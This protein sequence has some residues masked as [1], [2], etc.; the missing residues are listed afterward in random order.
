MNPTAPILRKRKISAKVLCVSSTFCL[1][2]VVLFTAIPLRAGDW[3][4]W[5][6]PTRTG[7]PTSDAPTLNSLPTELKPLW[8]ISIG[9]GFSSP[10][11]AKDRL[12]YLDE[13]GQREVAHLIDAKT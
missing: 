5:R 8:K 6:G 7:Y 10:V 4:Q 12:V 1:P 13:D 3:P 9:G 11:L 2:V